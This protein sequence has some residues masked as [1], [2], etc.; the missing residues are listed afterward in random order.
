MAF[1]RAVCL[2]FGI[3]ANWLLLGIEP[4]RNAEVA[5]SALRLAASS[6]LFAEVGRR[7]E[8]MGAGDTIPLL[9]QAAEIAKHKK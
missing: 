8:R 4:R 9:R 5:Q 7:I 1:L 6:E 2:Q 3:S